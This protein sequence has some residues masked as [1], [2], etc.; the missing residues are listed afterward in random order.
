MAR[1]PSPGRLTTCRS[2]PTLL[3]AIPPT[4]L[5]SFSLVHVMIK[6]PPQHRLTAFPPATDL[7]KMKTPP[8]HRL[9]ALLP[10]TALSK[11]KKPPRYHLTA[12]LSAT[13]SSKTK[14]PLRYRL[15]ASPPATV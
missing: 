6:T 4:R 2:S 5:A 10:A 15:T 9:T 13:A 1:S 14:T 3:K 11:T 7:S 8:R 12:F